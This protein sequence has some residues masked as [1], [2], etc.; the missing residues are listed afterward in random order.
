M[1]LLVIWAA[2]NRDTSQNI[3]NI[4]NIDKI[5]AGENRDTSQ[6]EYEPAEQTWPFLELVSG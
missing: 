2:E 5:W 3:D 4:D 1:T 6:D